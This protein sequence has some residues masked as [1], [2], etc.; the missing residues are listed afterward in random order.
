MKN[1][2]LNGIYEDKYTVL[3]GNVLSD[4]ALFEKISHKNTMSLR[5]NIIADVII[6]LAPKA[7]QLVK[8]GGTFITSGIIINRAGE[9][10]NELEKN[11][12]KSRKSS[13]AANGFR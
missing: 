2:G 12:L 5:Q 3:S 4:D 8:D 1:A 9:V 11:T 13:R 10:E 7:K 6:A